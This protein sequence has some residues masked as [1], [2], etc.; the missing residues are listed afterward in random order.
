MTSLTIYTYSVSIYTDSV[1]VHSYIVVPARIRTD[2]GTENIEVA[3]WMLEHHG[4]EKLSFITG[5]SVHNQRIERLW[6]DV[7]I[8]VICHFSNL[9]T[10]PES[11]SLLDSDDEIH[12]FALHFIFLPH[13]NLM[14]EELMEKWN[15]HP[16]HTEKNS[17][18][19]QLW[20]ESFYKSPDLMNSSN[21][22][23]GEFYGVDDDGPVGDIETVNNVQ[24]PETKHGHS[25]VDI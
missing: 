7:K 6:V 21:I 10:Y 16:L 15:N 4:I 22:N 19:L 20:T 8:Y 9:F 1:Y 18:P 23:I 2:Y 13:I 12:L 17:S 3:K 24:I 11:C 5:L 14:L 25:V